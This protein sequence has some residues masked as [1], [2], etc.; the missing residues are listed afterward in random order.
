M[1]S[2]IRSTDAIRSERPCKAAMSHAEALEQLHKV[3]G[4]RLD[5]SLI[6]VFVAEPEET[7]NQLESSLGQD[8]TFERTLQACERVIRA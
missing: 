8:L 3:S 2:T 7:W 6:E 5:P 1:A 4:K